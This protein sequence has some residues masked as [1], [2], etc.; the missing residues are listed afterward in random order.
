M[1]YLPDISPDK[2]QYYN[3]AALRKRRQR[4]SITGLKGQTVAPAPLR[5][6]FIY[7]DDM[8]IVKFGLDFENARLAKFKG[9]TSVRPEEWYSEPELHASE[10]W[11]SQCLDIIDA[12]LA[13][14]RGKTNG[15]VPNRN[16]KIKTTSAARHVFNVTKLLD[17][18]TIAGGPELQIKA[19]TIPG[20]WRA[21]AERIMERSCGAGSLFHIQASNVP[22]VEFGDIIPRDF[23]PL[24]LSS[25]EMGDFE[26][27]LNDAQELVN[28]LDVPDNVLF[29]PARLTHAPNL[30]QNISD[31]MQKFI[32][33]Q[34]CNIAMGRKTRTRILSDAGYPVDEFV[35]DF[36]ELN[37]DE[38]PT[39]H[40]PRWL[41]L[42]QFT[43]NPYF[44][45][46]FG[47]R[48]VCSYGRCEISLDPIADV[49]NSRLFPD[50]L[51]DYFSGD[52]VSQPRCKTLG[53]Y[54]WEPGW[55]ADGHARLKYLANVHNRSGIR[56][57]QL[58]TIIR[59]QS[60]VA[61]TKWIEQ[62]ENLRRWVG[63]GHWKHD[64]WTVRG[65]PKLVLLLSN[66]Q[67]L[68]DQGYE[69][70]EI[71]DCCVPYTSSDLSLPVA[72]L[73]WLESVDR[74]SRVVRQGEW[75]PEALMK[76]PRVTSPHAGV[77]LDIYSIGFNGSLFDNEVPVAGW[78]DKRYTKLLELVRRE[79]TVMEWTDMAE[80]VEAPGVDRWKRALAKLR[81]NE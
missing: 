72:K 32:Q 15:R 55:Q 54:M 8:N 49:P 9:V 70:D 44:K 35:N 46:L 80:G 47:S 22:P 13:S 64:I 26:P 79:V 77:L 2:A 58:L 6:N 39:P 81:D 68:S 62:V 52:F 4:R 24:Q 1:D 63:A 18:V 65:T 33:H 69:H 23:A 27:R 41:D 37:S 75:M 74:S 67:I 43:L 60:S 50:V 31:K 42:S 73:Q 7:Y 11:K 48:L 19:W 20:K 66:Q 71:H 53:L 76:S 51:L 59:K 28:R 40:E 25:T 36:G 5:P 12:R 29:F 57:G 17:L 78:K 10:M 45:G 14:Y 21:V 30:P 16:D 34:Y 38:Q 61:I 56:V 3:E